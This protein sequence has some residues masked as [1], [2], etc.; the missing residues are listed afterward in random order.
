MRTLEMRGA[1]ISEFLVTE[2]TYAR[3][4]R[5]GRHECDARMTVFGVVPTKKCLAMRP[6]VLDR[7]EARRKVGSVLQGLELHLGIRVV[8]RDVRPA[9]SLGD[10]EIVVRVTL[11]RRATSACATPRRRSRPARRRRRCNSFASR[12]DLLMSRLSN[13][14]YHVGQLIAIQVTS[15]LC[16]SQ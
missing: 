10:V 8:V 6:R 4:H 16:K 11:T 7:P 14:T 15:H 2:T 5:V 1:I 9:V 3:V 12:S 13:I